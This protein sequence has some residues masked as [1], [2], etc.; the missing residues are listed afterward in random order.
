[1]KKTKNF[2]NKNTLKISQIIKI[3]TSNMKIKRNHK[4]II[5]K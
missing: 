3:I 2:N 4:G 1:M 5:F